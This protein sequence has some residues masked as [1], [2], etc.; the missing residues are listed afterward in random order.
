MGSSCL[1]EM[2]GAANAR[3]LSWVKPAGSCA[4]SAGDNACRIQAASPNLLLSGTESFLLC[5]SPSPAEKCEFYHAAP[6]LVGMAQNTNLEKH[7]LHSLVLAIKASYSTE[8]QEMCQK[9]AT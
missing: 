7:N 9:V 2:S 8:S 3:V 4:D 6:L 5:S 1:L